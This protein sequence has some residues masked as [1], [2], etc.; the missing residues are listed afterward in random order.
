MS[1]DMAVVIAANIRRLREAKGLTQASLAAA[2]TDAGLPSVYPQ[3]ITK[4]ETGARALGFTEGIAIA[5]AL[6]VA[7]ETLAESEKRP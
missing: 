1:G 2:L 6:G 5:C 7:P 4:I 3:T